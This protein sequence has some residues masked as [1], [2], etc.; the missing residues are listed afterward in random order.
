NSVRG[1]GGGVERAVRVTPDDSPGAA[2]WLGGG[3]VGWWSKRITHPLH[4]STPF[5]TSPCQQH[6]Q[7]QR[8]AVA[9]FG[10]DLVYRAARQRPARRQRVERRQAG[11]EGAFADEREVVE[12][13]RV[14]RQQ[15][16]VVAG[17][18]L[19]GGSS[20]VRILLG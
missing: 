2:K 9:L 4:H 11:D 6:R 7:E 16:A 5:Q 18:Q 12:R 3:V 13:V 1:Q 15:P 10:E 8:C 20:V 14:E 19:H 17:D